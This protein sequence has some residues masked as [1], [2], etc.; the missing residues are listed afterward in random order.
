MVGV[1]GFA[2]VVVAAGFETSAPVAAGVLIGRVRRFLATFL[3]GPN[4]HFIAA[5]GAGVSINRLPDLRAR[6]ETIIGGIVAAPVVA[7]APVAGVAA[8]SPT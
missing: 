2:G 5:P 3:V 7:A 4:E 8:M 1:V 6:I